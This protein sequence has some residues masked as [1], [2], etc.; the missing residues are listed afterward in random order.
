MISIVHYFSDRTMVKNL[1]FLLLHLIVM[2][3][4]IPSQIYAQYM[5][6]LVDIQYPQYIAAEEKLS[7]TMTVTNTGP[8]SWINVCAYVGYLLLPDGTNTLPVV[9]TCPN[10]GTVEPG[11]Y[12]TF[13]CST[14]GVI[15]G[16]AERVWAG[17]GVPFG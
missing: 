6:E 12:G 15:P 10:L 16:T 2:T 7:I 11:E 17:I 5:G 13:K 1:L 8:G 14:D 3:I 9:S 4:A